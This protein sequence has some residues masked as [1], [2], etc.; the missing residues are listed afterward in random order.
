MSDEYDTYP[1]R[2]SPRADFHDYSC[3][4]YFVTICT[5]DNGI[6]LARLTMARC[7]CRQSVNLLMP[8]LLVYRHII[9]IPMC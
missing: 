9:P 8:S 1:R 3:G 7:V 5:N 4:D 2:K 6:I